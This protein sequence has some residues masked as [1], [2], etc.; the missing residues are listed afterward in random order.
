Y[1]RL[2]RILFEDG[3]KQAP[4]QLIGRDDPQGS[5]VLVC[6]ALV[7]GQGKT[8]GLHERRI[9]VPP[10]AAGF[11]RTGDLEPIAQLSQQRIEQAGQVSKSLRTALMVLFQNGPERAKF[12]ARDRSSSDHAKTF[13]DR[14]ENEIDRDFF[15]RLFEEVETDGD[16]AQR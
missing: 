12:N 7:C 16:S 9:R 5:Y 2:S 3:F 11:W 13:L 6:R 4:L 1:K 10:K 8:K 15:E 14:F